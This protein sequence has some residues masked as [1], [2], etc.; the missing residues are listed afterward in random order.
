[1]ATEFT[2]NATRLHPYKNFSFRIKWDGRNVAGVSKISGLKHTTEVVKHRED[3]DPSSSLK[4]PGRTEFDALALER[5]VT[6]DAEFEKWAKNVW[7]FT[8]CTA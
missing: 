8:A 2:G 6:H 1:M 4:S 3:A 5:G 7:N